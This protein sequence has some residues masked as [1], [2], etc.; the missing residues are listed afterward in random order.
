ME[1]GKL[2]DASLL[3]LREGWAM[4]SPAGLALLLLFI[5]RPS[6]ASLPQDV[7]MKPDP[8]PP[9]CR[10]H[11]PDRGQ[12]QPIDLRRVE[13]RYTKLRADL[14][15]SLG[16]AGVEFSRRLKA[17]HD[18]ALPACRRRSVRKIVLPEP[19]PRGLRRRLFYFASVPPSGPL[20]LPP[21]VASDRRAEILIVKVGRRGS[22][23][24]LS[25]S[26]K[27]RVNL[28]SRD[29]ARALGVRCANTMVEIKEKGNVLVLHEGR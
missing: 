6:A 25:R 1:R 13:R 11:H 2:K 12:S 14:K 28:A 17:G 3:I 24:E 21:E 23:G 20:H 5:C 26:L 18:L 8:A 29:V 19:V 7:R 27:R 9:L 4:A 22:L 16:R 15:R 10:H